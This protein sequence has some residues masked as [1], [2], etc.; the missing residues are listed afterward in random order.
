MRT[1][2]LPTRLWTEGLVFGVALGFCLGV[3]V[4]FILHIITLLTEGRP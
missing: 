2:N 4:G 3:P 1:D